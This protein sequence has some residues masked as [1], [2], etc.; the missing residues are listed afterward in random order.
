M[1]SETAMFDVLVIGGGVIG[2]A[3]ARELSRWRLRVLVCERGSDVCVGTSKANS[4]IVHAGHSAKPGSLMAKYNVLGNALFDRLCSELDVP[5]RRNGSLT[6]CFAQEDRPKLDAL[7]A[8]GIANGVPQMR[9]IERDELMRMEPHINPEVVAALHTGTGGIVCPYELTVAL[10]ENAAMN[11]VEIRCQSAVTGLRPLTGGGWLVQ[12]KQG[13]LR[14][15]LVVNAAGLYAD[16]INN[17]ASSQPLQ[18]I[19]RRGEYWLMDKACAG[20]FTA[21]LFQLPGAMGKGVLVTPTVDGSILIGPTAEDIDDKEDLSTTQAGLDQVLNVARRTWPQLPQRS[22]IANF[23]G[24]RAHLSS[25]DFVIGEAPGAPG[26]YNA[27]GIESPGLTAAPAIAEEL[28]RQMVA[29]LKPQARAEFQP[30]RV[31]LRRFR[32]L[33]DAERAAAIA[34]DPAFGRMVCR[35]EMVT[36]AEVRDAIR[37]P[38]GAR[39]VDGVKRRTRA[40]MGRCQGGFCLPRVLAILS[41]E[42]GISPLAVT[43]DSAESNILVARLNDAEEQNS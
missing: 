23:A 25:H 24:L 36:E 12:T 15:R 39:T 29:V 11:G 38:V 14:T 41:E 27:A 13:E 30:K 37:R 35:C 33:T 32:D 17:M 42:L 8:D 3:V 21:T 6:L 9:I 20:L 16:E 22:A 7:Y 2:C 34:H 28:C 18:I 5:F 1:K 4:S 10:A 40:G 26:F 19:P 43:K 31:G